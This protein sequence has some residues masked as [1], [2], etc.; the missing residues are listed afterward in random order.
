MILGADLASICDY[1][2]SLSYQE[3]LCQYLITGLI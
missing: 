2:A 1:L 3:L